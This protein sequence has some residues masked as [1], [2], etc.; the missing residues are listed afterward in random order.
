[1]IS[2]RSMPPKERSTWRDTA[3]GMASTE[4]SC[5]HGGPHLVEKGFTVE[6]G[7]PAGATVELGAAP[8]KGG[9]ASRAGI[10]SRRLVMLVLPRPGLLGALRPDHPELGPR[11]ASGRAKCDKPRCHDGRT[12]SGVRIARHSS[13]D[14]ILL[15]SDIVRIVDLK[16]GWEKR[17][18]GEKYI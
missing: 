15:A 12:C 17:L 5:Q 4:L 3:P 14:L 8:V 13:S 16:G 11:F 7:W 2:V 18:W 10:D 9:L 6:K 1:M